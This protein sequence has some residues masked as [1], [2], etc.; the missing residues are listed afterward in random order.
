[1]RASHRHFA[2]LVLF[3]VLICSKVSGKEYQQL[4]LLKPDSCIRLDKGLVQRLPDQW[5]RY[6]D[7][8]KICRLRDAKSNA[9]AS[10]VSIWVLDYYNAKF[11]APTPRVWE[12]FPLPLIVDEDFKPVGQL[13]ENYPDDPPRELEIYYSKKVSDAPPQIRVKVYN[14]AVT[15]DYSYPPMIWNKKNKRYEMKGK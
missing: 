1:M 6:G 15:G 7:F 4:K 2:L 11:P 8:V 13:P 5:Q 14:P 3:S 10:I 9:R 12:E